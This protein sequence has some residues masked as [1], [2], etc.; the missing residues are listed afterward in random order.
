MKLEMSRVMWC[1]AC[2]KAQRPH[3]E[4]LFAV[5]GTTNQKVW[6]YYYEAPTKREFVKPFGFTPHFIVLDKVLDGIAHLFVTCGCNECGTQI[7][8]T[9]EKG[10]EVGIVKTTPITMPLKDYLALETFTDTGYKM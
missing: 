1:E 9:Q 7:T 3:D 4:M 5:L 6:V 10:W 2:F 8:Y